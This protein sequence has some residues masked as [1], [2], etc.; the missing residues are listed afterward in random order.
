MLSPS[1]HIFPYIIS[2]WLVKFQ[3]FI[4][5][6]SVFFFLLK[7]ILKQTSIIWIVVNICMSCVYVW[8][9]EYYFHKNVYGVKYCDAKTESI[10]FVDILF[11]QTCVAGTQSAPAQELYLFQS[12][13]VINRLMQMTYS[14]N[15]LIERERMLSKGASLFNIKLKLY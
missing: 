11:L 9:P 1:I 6:I 5:M 4:R 3:G 10:R 7:S 12:T 2:Q 15:Q 13:C 8:L 14:W